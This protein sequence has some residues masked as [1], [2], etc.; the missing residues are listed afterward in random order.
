MK[1]NLVYQDYFKY[2]NNTVHDAL[3]TKKNI[4]TMLLNS[5]NAL[6][7]FKDVQP[8]KMSVFLGKTL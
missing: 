6:V 7:D 1:T 2:E 3:L 4:T 5:V 8:M